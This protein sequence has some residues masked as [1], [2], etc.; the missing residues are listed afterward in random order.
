M[1]A[2]VHAIQIKKKKN[3]KER[4]T[5][6]D[7]WKEVKTSILVGIQKQLAAALVGDFEGPKHQK[8]KE[9]VV[10]EVG[11]PRELELELER[12]LRWQSPEFG[13]L[14]HLKQKGQ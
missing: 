2:H 1:H 5:F 4:R 6:F 9:L 13:S 3:K 10:H 14:K 12:E 11:G 8:R 7:S